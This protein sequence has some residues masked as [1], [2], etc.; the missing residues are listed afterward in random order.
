MLIIYMAQHQGHG[1][2]KVKKYTFLSA[3]EG[4]FAVLQTVLFN[5]KC[6]T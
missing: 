5:L 4:D 3:V 2:L 6:F 1:L